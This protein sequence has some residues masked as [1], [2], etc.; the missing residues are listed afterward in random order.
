M[1]QSDQA[2]FKKP[3]LPTEKEKTALQGLFQAP[4]FSQI[5]WGRMTQPSK[6]ATRGWTESER[7]VWYYKCNNRGNKC[8]NR[9]NKCSKRGNKCN[10][11][12]GNKCNKKYFNSRKANIDN[13]SS[14]PTEIKSHDKDFIREGVFELSS[15]TYFQ[16]NTSRGIQ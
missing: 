1:T 16:L 9:G 10:N 13:T 14:E 3:L 5:A 7:V 4:Q 12:K 15:P 6:W 2:G 8:N 11:K